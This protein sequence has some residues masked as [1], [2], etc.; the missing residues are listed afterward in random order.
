MISQIR[1]EGGEE[2]GNDDVND[3]DVESE[4]GDE[5]GGMGRRS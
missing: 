4:D 5:Y 2:V 1:S 3:G